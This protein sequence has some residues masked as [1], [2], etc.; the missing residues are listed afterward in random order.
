MSVRCTYTVIGGG[1]IGNLI[2]NEIPSG[3]VDSSNTEFTLAN[4]PVIGTVEVYLNGLLQ[5]PG[6]GNDYT[7][8]GTGISFSKAPRTGSDILVSYAID[9]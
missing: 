7:I 2:V 6:T 8:S 3:T 1:A 5:V 4:T 9:V